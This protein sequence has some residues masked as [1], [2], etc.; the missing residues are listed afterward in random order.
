MF[1]PISL[2]QLRTELRRLMNAERELRGSRSAVDC[3]Q[4]YWKPYAWKRYQAERQKLREKRA[5]FKGVAFALGLTSQQVREL[6]KEIR[7]NL[8][9]A[10]DP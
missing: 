10:S 4:S 5:R 3:Q 2:L 7:T 6:R 8:S 9:R 1:K